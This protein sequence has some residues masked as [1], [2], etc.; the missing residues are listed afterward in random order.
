MIGV[1]RREKRKKGEVLSKEE[2]KFSRRMDQRSPT[3]V[4]R[5]MN[6]KKPLLMHIIVRCQKSKKQKILNKT[7]HIQRSG[8]RTLLVLLIAREAHEE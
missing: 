2:C 1:P 6:D 5:T 7:A 3:H 8:I 4:P